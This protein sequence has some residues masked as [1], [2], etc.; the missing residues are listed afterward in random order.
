MVRTLRIG[1]VA[2]ISMQVGEGG[3]MDKGRHWF[4]YVQPDDFAPTTQAAGFS[5]VST[6]RPDD[7]WVI[8][9]GYKR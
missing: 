9:I 7:R 5:N 1:D 2:A 4:T 8:A 3:R 6:R